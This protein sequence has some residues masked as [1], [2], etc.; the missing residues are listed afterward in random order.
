VKR[1]GG[2]SHGYFFPA[3]QGTLS[4]RILGDPRRHPIPFAE[5]AEKSPIRRELNRIAGIS[6]QNLA[7]FFIDRTVMGGGAEDFW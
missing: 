6:R 7:G 2:S 3:V 5:V 1:S 4:D